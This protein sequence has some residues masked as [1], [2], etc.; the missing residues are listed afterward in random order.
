MVKTITKKTNVKKP[1][2]TSYKKANSK[3]MGYCL[4]CK[5]HVLLDKKLSLKHRKLPNNRTVAILC[6]FCSDCKTK[7]CKIIAN[8]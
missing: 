3:I 4:Q 6:G 7:V 8:Y 5:K 1:T 2:L